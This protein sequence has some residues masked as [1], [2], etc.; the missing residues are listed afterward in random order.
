M[1]KAR[2]KY[3]FFWARASASAKRFSNFY[4]VEDGLTVEWPDMPEIPSFLRG[5]TR[6][7]PTTE[8]AYQSLKVLA[9]AL[10]FG[11]DFWP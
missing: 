9:L 10:A 7:Y 2:T 8:H 4:D 6:V 3:L 11:L 1:L 5:L